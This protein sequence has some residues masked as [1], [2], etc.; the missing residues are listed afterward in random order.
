VRAV[1][2]LLISRVERQAKREG[3]AYDKESRSEASEAYR[4]AS[5]V[6]KEERSIAREAA[7]QAG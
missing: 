1:L 2:D 6:A 3:K 5:L 4:R 7:R